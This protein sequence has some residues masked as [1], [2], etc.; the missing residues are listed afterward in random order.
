MEDEPRKEE[1]ADQIDAATAEIVRL[2]ADV[3]RL[4]VASAV[5]LG[6]WTPDEIART[7]E[8]DVRVVGRALARLVAGGLLEE[9]DRGTYRF[10]HEELQVV[11]RKSAAL[12]RAHDPLDAAPEAAKVL[13]R[14]FK[15]GRLV[16]IPLTRSKRLVVLDYLVQMFEPGRYYTEA[17][18]NA[19]LARYHADVAA[20]RRYLV[21]EGLLARTSGRYWRAGGTFEVP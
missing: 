15:R 3:E 21:D 16:S 5:V 4:K 19:L 2:L 7:T 20:L 9:V 17:D 11:A 12:E 14:F 8:L 6:A 10:V 18:V 1:D 13:R